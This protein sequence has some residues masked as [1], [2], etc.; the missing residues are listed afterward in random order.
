MNYGSTTYGKWNRLL[1]NKDVNILPA[2]YKND[3]NS[4]PIN[5]IFYAE[6]QGVTGTPT[7]NGLLFSVQGNDEGIQLWAGDNRTE[8]YY[9]TKWVSFGRWFKLAT[10]SD[11]N[12]YLTK[13]EASTLYYPYNGRGYL[14]IT[15]TGRP[16]MSNNQGYA[17]KDTDGNEKEVLWM[18]TDNSLNLGNTSQYTLNKL[19]LRCTT[20]THNGKAIATQE[21]VNNRSVSWS[22]IT[23]KPS[24]YTPSAHSHKSL[25]IED[26]R[27]VTMLPNNMGPTT[28]R[29]FFNANKMPTS[30]WY[31]GIHISGWVT[32]YA[33]WQLCGPSSNNTTVY[34]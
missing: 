24:T 28:L 10:T 29:T 2:S 23:G 9:R 6:T 7:D 21:Y 17:V 34:Q 5:Q 33:A 30:D 18:G 19:D 27:N 1:T 22:N 31:S 25:Q 14:S 8:L 3:P 11:L 16:V 15:S 26:N 32:N 20:L 13:T 12:S 4:L